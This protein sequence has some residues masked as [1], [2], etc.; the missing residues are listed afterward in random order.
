MMSGIHG[1]QNSGRHAVVHL[2]VQEAGK[3]L[4]GPQVIDH[5]HC[6]ATAE[7]E[8]R[9]TRVIVGLLEPARAAVRRRMVERVKA[10]QK[11][12]PNVRV[13]LLADRVVEVS[14]AVSQD[15]KRGAKGGKLC[16]R[17]WY[18]ELGP[19]EL[20]WRRKTGFNSPVREWVDGPA[21]GAIRERAREAAAGLGGRADIPRTARPQLILGL[22]LLGSWLQCVPSARSCQ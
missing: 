15:R 20:A 11:R 14:K 5:M 9:P 17:E 10:L 1:E 16:L 8:G 13:P 6:Q 22:C 2:V 3:P 18:A 7:G 19:P 12:A 21:G 4:I